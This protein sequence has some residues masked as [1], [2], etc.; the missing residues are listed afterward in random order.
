[1]SAEHTLHPRPRLLLSVTR[2]WG[3]RW[4]PARVRTAYLMHGYAA[5][6][7]TTGRADL[8][9]LWRAGFLDLHLFGGQLI[10]TLKESS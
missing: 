3:G 10:Y 1:V 8:N 2:S 6:Q 4:T 5:S 7:R 9:L